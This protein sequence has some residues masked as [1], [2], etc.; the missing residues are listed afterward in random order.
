MEKVKKKLLILGSTGMLGHIIFQYFHQEDKFELFD[1]VYRDKLREESIVCDINNTSE[2]KNIIRSIQPDFI[3]NCIGI[4]LKGSRRNPSNSIFVNSYFPHFL[5]EIAD[6]INSKVIHISTDCVF[7][8]LKGR[9]TETGFRD[10]DDIYGRSKALG[11]IFSEKHLTLRTS[12]VGPEIK[13]DGE[14]LFHWFMNQTGEVNGFTKVFWSGVTTLQLAEN[15]EQSI[16]YNYTGLLH[17]TNEIPISKFDLLQLFKLIWKRD[18]ISILPYHGK[19]IDKSLISTLGVDF[20][21]P[22]Y[23]EMLFK[24]YEWMNNRNDF[25]SLYH[26]KY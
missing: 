20:K 2:F 18:S 5:V 11:E 6:D 23:Y 8:G 1:L 22:S 16:H 25:Y 26:S 24:Q 19:S 21:V 7:S 13:K 10:A 4:L 12:I 14:G 17:V 9:Y 15:I 3:I